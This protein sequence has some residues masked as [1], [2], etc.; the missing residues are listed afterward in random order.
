[1]RRIFLILFL[2]PILTIAQ[3]LDAGAKGQNSIEYYLNAYKQTDGSTGTIL[4]VL[5]FVDKLKQKEES[6]ERP[7]DFLAYLFHKTHQRFLRYYH[8]EA[9][10]G[11]LLTDRTYNCLTA[12]AL[13]A[14]LLDHFDLDYKVIETN[15]HIFLITQTSQGVVLLETTDPTNGFVTDPKEI[16]KRIAQY[17]EN[18][19]EKDVSNKA[20]YYRFKVDMYKEVN[21]DQMLGLLY[22]NLSIQAY[23]HQKLPLAIEQLGLAAKLYHSDRIDEFSKILLLSVL[24]SNFE[25]RMKA[26]YLQNIQSFRKNQLDA[27]ASSEYLAT[28]QTQ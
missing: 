18:R 11:Q 6:F 4:P 1:M 17:R 10:F 19:I 26:R 2:A 14:L 13:Y 15:Y 24:E 12:T 23:N 16:E 20:T 28:Q 25:V 9:S 8:E 22:Y 7:N 5:S 21:L 3:D 27:T